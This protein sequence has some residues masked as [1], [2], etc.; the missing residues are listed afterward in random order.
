MKRK[1][2][3]TI[4]LSK[5]PEIK[6]YDFNKPF[7]FDE[8]I[9]S[10]SNIGIQATNLAKAINITN[11]M[12]REKVPIYFSFTSNIISSGL[13]DIIT[14]L[15]KNKFVSVLCTSAGGIEEDVMKARMPFYLGSFDA[16][17]SLLHDLGILRIGNI[18]TTEEHYT[19]F[20][21]FIRKVF[22][23][24]LK[25]YEKK[26]LPITPSRISF[27]IGK[28]MEKEKNYKKE[29]S[30]LY[31]AYKNKI[32]VYCP[33]IVDGAIGDI[34]Y[35]FKKEN[36]NFHIDL[37]QD[38]IKLIDYTINQKKTGAIILGGGISK[39]YL[40]NANIFKE[41]LDYVVY[42]NTA[43]PDDASDSG[44]NQEEAI[45]WSKIKPNALRVKV[46]GEASLVFPL[47]VAATFAK[48]K[49]K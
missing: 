5:L 10:Y 40:L 20:E 38:H 7:D 4:D 27:F 47:L 18:Y 14:Y 2:K 39:H 30:Y 11:I 6:G 45:T 43:I 8:F 15:V 26:S 17:G 32:P 35:Y 28:Q 21:F 41:G 9:K 16:K 34:A 49:R 3:K 37:M 46:Y 19:Y 42:I 22:S 1:I 36:P 33:G 13:R 44:G 24:L 23:S 12:L 29:S 48:Q 31:W 25:E